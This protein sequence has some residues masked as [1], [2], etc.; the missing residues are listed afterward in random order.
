MPASVVTAVRK[1]WAAEIKDANGKLSTR[2][3]NSRPR[4]CVDDAKSAPDTTG[5]PAK[6]KILQG[7]TKSTAP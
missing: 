3:R 5:G 6:L 2:R 7:L 1:L 4:Q